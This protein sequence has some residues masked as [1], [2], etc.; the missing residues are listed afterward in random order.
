MLTTTRTA[1][2]KYTAQVA[3]LNGVPSATSTFAVTPTV[4]QKLEERIQQSS[5]FLQEVN[6]VGVDQLKGEVL[7]LLAA[8]PVA[9]R[10]DTTTKDREPRSIDDLGTR[11]YECA[12][13]DFDSFISYDKLDVWAKFPDFQTRVR[14]KVIEQIGRDRL[15]IGWNGTSVAVNTDPVAHPLLQDVNI[16]WLAHLRTDAPQR[17]MTGVKMGNGGDYR[18]IDALALDTTNSLLDEWYR[19][20][21][22]VVAIIGRELLVDKYMAMLNSPDA[23]APM[24]KQAMDMI[25]MNRT[26]GSH[27]AVLVPFFPPRAI[28]FT[29]LKNLSIYYQNGSRRRRIEDQPRRN[30]I[31]D[32][33]SINESYV[34]EDPG[35]CALVENIQLPDG[36][37]GWA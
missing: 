4:E 21:R 33:Q 10:T 13:T 14:N 29:K 2:D 27:Q 30:R 25:L 34:I 6:V 15:M 22:G 32:Y 8:A 24:Q 7:G 31:V 11:G 36:A 37:G 17:V 5:A 35:A 16:G 20:D 18:N 12:K 3:T 26:I 1:F 19:D 23:D 9:G 28:L